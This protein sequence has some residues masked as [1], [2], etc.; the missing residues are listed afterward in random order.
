MIWLVGNRGMLGTEVEALLQQHNL[1][2]FASDR[3]VDITD[4]DRLKQF[5][6]GKPLSWIINCSAYTAVDKAEDDPELAFQINAD[7]PRNLA[8]V[9][10]S[11]GAKL[12]HIST[13]YVFDG[14]K[15]GAYKETDTPNP[16][17]V[18]GASKYRG[19][20]Y[21]QKL[22]KA[23]F[24]LRTSWLYGKNGNNFVYTMLRLFRERD[25][26]RVLGD[27]WGSPTYASDLAEAL[28][29]IVQLNSGD[30]GIYHFTNE[31]NVSWYDFACEIYCMARN[32]EFLT[33]DVLIQRIVTAEYPTKA[34]RP[35][36]SCMSKEKIRDVFHIDARP[37][38]E[39]LQ[40]FFTGIE[41]R[42]KG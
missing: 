32:K 41:N 33:K 20:V 23:S 27:Q 10:L 28:L 30:Y 29:D 34:H 25:E 26:V 17:G 24:I 38:Q 3:E 9:A 14:T 5:V 18:Y 2:Y 37:W 8:G 1:Q 13:D 22:L 4:A 39:G 19:E 15:E 31:G 40:D 12:I 35:L 7:G 16:L 11:K 36:N 42:Q 21:I 6:S